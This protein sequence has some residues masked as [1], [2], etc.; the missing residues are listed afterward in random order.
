MIEEAHARD[1][2][3]ERWRHRAPR[4]RRGAECSS[5]EPRQ[6]DTPRGMRTSRRARGGRVSW[7]HSCTAVRRHSWR[8]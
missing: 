6:E 5:P 7:C 1:R 4:N 2:E 3:R 8:I